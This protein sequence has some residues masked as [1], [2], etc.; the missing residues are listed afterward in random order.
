MN[1]TNDFGQPIG[2]DLDGWQSPPL[3]PV[4]PLVGRTVTLEPLDAD[5]H[6]EALHQAYAAG[7][8]SLWTYMPAGPF[9][10]VAELH[11]TI[12]RICGPEDWRSYAHIVDGT[13]VGMQSF[14]RIM[15]GPGSIE[16]G[17]VALSPAL[18]RT[19][20]ST[21]AHYL[22]IAHAFELGYRRV[23]WKCD[24]FNAA[25]RAAALR[26]GFQYE[27]IFRQATNYKG[28]SRDTAWFAI[29]DSEWPTIEAS[30]QQWLAPENFDEHGTQ[31]KPLRF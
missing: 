26:L 21:E 16:I 28:R 15:P 18:Q 10:T 27:G 2:P 6:A 14:L 4:A 1:R 24:H 12:E 22:M 25:S 9:G 3:P 30:Y 17:W 20:A 23:E 29:I 19:T 8:D 11:S 31:V 5:R 13:A 7:P